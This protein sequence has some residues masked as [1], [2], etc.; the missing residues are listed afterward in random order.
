MRTEKDIFSRTSYYIMG[1][2]DES[3]DKPKREYTY[4][5]NYRDFLE[6]TKTGNQSFDAYLES[7]SREMQIFDS[8]DPYKMN[9]LVPLTNKADAFLRKHAGISYEDFLR[10]AKPE[11]F[12]GNDYG[13]LPEKRNLRRRLFKHRSML[14][15]SALEDAER[16]GY[17]LKE[18]LQEVEQRTIPY[19][20]KERDEPTFQEILKVLGKK[21]QI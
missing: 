20:K 21:N 19:L 2:Q 10:Q 11:D 3:Y 12:T 7:L 15:L 18:L 5:L 6:R 17:N 9:A 4:S 1:K 13:S 14:Y 16:R 8:I